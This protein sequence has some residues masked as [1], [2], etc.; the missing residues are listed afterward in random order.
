MGLLD[1]LGQ[2][3]DSIWGM[4]NRLPSLFSQQETP[5]KKD[6]S[7]AKDF[8]QKAEG[9]RNKYYK[10]TEGNWTSG[11]GHLENQ[12]Q[13]TAIIN[14]KEEVVDSS[15]NVVIIDEGKINKQYNEDVQEHGNAGRDFFGR[16]AFDKL[17]ENVQS[18][19]TS[20]VF[21]VGVGKEAYTDA[22]GK[23]HR[24]TGVKAY[25]RMK[26][27]VENFDKESFV[28]SKGNSRDGGIAGI[29]E[30]LLY[31]NYNE[32]PNT[33]S[34]RYNKTGDRTGKE[35]M[36]MLN[37]SPTRK[38]M[39]T[40]EPIAPT[41]M[42]PLKLG[43]PT[44]EYTP[45]GRPLLL[46][47][48]GGKSSEYS[49]GVKDPRINNKALTHIPSIYDGNILN[50]KDAIQEV[51]DAGGYDRLTGRYIEEGGD[52]NARS[53]SLKNIPHHIGGATTDTSRYRQ[54]RLPSLQE[55]AQT[56]QV[57]PALAPFHPSWLRETYDRRSKVGMYPEKKRFKGTSMYP[58]PKNF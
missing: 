16:E 33:F 25:K 36:H 13:N 41:P 21:N 31:T 20:L 28:D 17:P 45:E 23:Y 37:P 38:P 54:Q 32:K 26:E 46:N 51:V 4:I 57:Q 18:V 35:I 15:G 34:P 39:S 7:F 49:I 14:G 53:M 22:A 6:F 50:Q 11:V 24:A 12:N 44:G 56:A 19:L 58:L 40:L 10:D 48:Q 55:V 47:N 3:T 29:S 5:Q 42:Q 30:E 2:P 8:I 9:R 43:D 52:P 1:I 27:A